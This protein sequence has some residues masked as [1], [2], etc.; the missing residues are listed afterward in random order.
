V[1]GDAFIVELAELDALGDELLLDAGV[2]VPQAAAATLNASI[3]APKRSA[4]RCMRVTPVRV[5]T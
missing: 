3:A 2:A 5:L 1:L 4:G